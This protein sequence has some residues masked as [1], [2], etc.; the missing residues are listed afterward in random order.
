M[1]SI[2]IN[3]RIPLSFGKKVVVTAET[4]DHLQKQGLALHDA[5]VY[6]GICV[7]SLKKA[8]RRMGVMKWRQSK[9]AAFPIKSSQQKGIPK[10]GISNP[11]VGSVEQKLARELHLPQT[12]VVSCH[13]CS[14]NSQFDRSPD[15]SWKIAVS[16]LIH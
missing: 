6:L 7:S 13:Q 3:A 1:H 8:C 12:S 10:D 14:I 2:S 4:I 16:N 15:S 11:A 9:V 5:S